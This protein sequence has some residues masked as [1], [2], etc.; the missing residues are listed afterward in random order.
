[1]YAR[2]PFPP[3]I[4]PILPVLARTLAEA[5]VLTRTPKTFCIAKVFGNKIIAQRGGTIGNHDTVTNGNTIIN[6]DNAS[7]INLNNSITIN[8]SIKIIYP[9][10]KLY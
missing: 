7:I 2:P 8:D 5:N 6:L 9:H 3:I 1:M 4:P 10:T